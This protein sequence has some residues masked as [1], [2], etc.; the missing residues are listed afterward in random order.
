MPRAEKDSDFRGLRQAA[1]EQGWVVEK[2]A[3]NHWKFLPPKEENRPV[4]FSGSPGD[5][6]AL[7]NFVSALRRSGFVP[8]R[9]MRKGG[10]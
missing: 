10:K 1:Q 5:W 4:Y 6:R 2:T 8:P 9:N 3:N 7:R